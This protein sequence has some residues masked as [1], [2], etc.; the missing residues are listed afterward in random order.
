M[1]TARC[2]TSDNSNGKAV[3]SC[4]NRVKKVPVKAFDAFRDPGQLGVC[5]FKRTKE[6]TY[7]L[8]TVRSEMTRTPPS[9]SLG[10]MLT[11]G[12]ETRKI[13]NSPLKLLPRVPD[14]NYPSTSKANAL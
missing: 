4:H 14:N 8:G 2:E 11:C 12:T 3:P 1:S 6:Q 13:E 9:S 7:A 10:P 5:I